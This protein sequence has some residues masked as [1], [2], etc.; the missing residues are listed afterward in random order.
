M[1]RLKVRLHLRCKTVLFFA[2]MHKDRK[3][4]RVAS[5]AP[6]LPSE[7]RDSK[8]YLLWVRAVPVDAVPLRWSKPG[9]DAHNAA[10]NPYQIHGGE[11]WRRQ[12]GNATQ[13]G[14]AKKKKTTKNKSLLKRARPRTWRRTKSLYARS[15]F[16]RKKASRF[17][18][19]K[20]KNP[21]RDQVNSTNP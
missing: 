7:N 1:I 3:S 2:L 14:C 11:E 12:R 5:R 13:V 9:A 8:W 18:G 17:S 4:A 19:I 6:G 16:T 15:G 10:H 21:Q 20:K